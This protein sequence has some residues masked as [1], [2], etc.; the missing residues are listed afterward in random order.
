MTGTLSIATSNVTLNLGNTVT[1]SIGSLSGSYDLGSEIATLNLTNFSLGLNDASG[2][3]LANLAVAGLSLQYFAAQSDPRMLLGATGVSVTLGTPGSGPALAVSQGTLAVAIYSGGTYAMEV[4]GTVQLSGLP[5]GISVGAGNVQV[6]VNNTGDVVNQTI[7]VNGQSLALSFATTASV[8]AVNVSGFTL[9]I[10]NFVTVSGNFSFSRNSGDLIVSATDVTASLGDGSMGVS[11]T[12]GTL[13]LQINANKT[14]ALEVSGGVSLFGFG[15]ALQFSATSATL[16][17]NNSTAS[18]TVPNF[19][20]AIP[21]GTTLAITLS[22][23]SLNI[24]GLATIMGSFSF[25]QSSEIGV[26]GAGTTQIDV[27]GT[28]ISATVGSSS[29]G[30]SLGGISFGLV[31]YRSTGGAATYALEAVAQTFSLNGIP[32]FNLSSLNGSPGLSIMINTTGKKVDELLPSGFTV[33]FTDG[34]NNTPDQRNLFDVEGG[35]VVGVS[36]FG[37]N[38][39]LQGQFA[40]SE[41]TV[42]GTSQ[43]KLLIGASNITL[44]A[45]I[46]SV[47]FGI[48]NGTLALAI[49]QNSGGST[50]ALDL[51]G[52]ASLNIGGSNGVTVSTGNAGQL[53]PAHQQYRAPG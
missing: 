21:A 44:S 10:G 12:N 7:N 49:Y 11:V 52:G 20:T 24:A 13:G 33:Q 30:L 31:L 18:I 15:S 48:T 25:S 23:A 50:Y 27:G 53:S 5:A 39:S 47:V 28:G 19:S 34:T 41:S 16:Q 36:A 38:I 40:F 1:T 3:Q 42:A 51:S 43:T 14:Y 9:S 4:G 46:D 26:N 32:G 35:I 8:L 2:N 29:F 45:T 22:G 17:V 6:L 37:V